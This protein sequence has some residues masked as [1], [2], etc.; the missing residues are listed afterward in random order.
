[1]IYKLHVILDS[2][3]K[4]NQREALRNTGQVLFYLS[5]L[6]YHSTLASN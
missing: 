2:H 6:T 1:M 3:T 4:I 5:Y